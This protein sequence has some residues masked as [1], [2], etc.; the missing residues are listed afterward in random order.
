MLCNIRNWNGKINEWKIISYQI[1]LS[2]FY[3]I[4]NDRLLYF[5][6]NNNKAN[7]INLKIMIKNHIKL[8]LS[9]I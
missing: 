7:N 9:S 8:L 2:N 3:F 4:F 6:L 1:I 5:L